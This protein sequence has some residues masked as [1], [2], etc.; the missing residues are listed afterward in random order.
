[1]D[2]RSLGKGLVRTAE[3]AG[4]GGLAGLVATAAMTLS[5]AVEMRVRG[6]KASSVPS[7]AAGKVLGVQPRNPD[8]AARFANYAHWSYGLT[9]GALGGMMRMV[10]AE[11]TASV[12]HFASVWGTEVVLLPTLD[13]VPELPEWG[14]GEVM[15]DILHHAVYVAAFAAAWHLMGEVEEES[16]LVSSVMDRF[17]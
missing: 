11:P 12:T 17:R 15:V 6:R 5:S 10:V 1:M 7:D 16:S 8:G 13:V 9:W 4:K 2:A 3:S 14:G